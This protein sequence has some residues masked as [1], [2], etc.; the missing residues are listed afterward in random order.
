MK[1]ITLLSFP[2]YICLTIF[3][4]WLIVVPFCNWG[5]EM[6]EYFLQYMFRKHYYFFVTKTNLKQILTIRI[7]QN[8]K[9]LFQLSQYNPSGNLHILNVSRVNWDHLFAKTTRL[10]LQYHAWDVIYQQQQFSSAGL[11]T[12]KY[13]K[14]CS[15]DTF[16]S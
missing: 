8:T 3:Y 10:F 12:L 11:A 1:H 15:S 2:R 4:F 13:Y 5:N 7:T 16:Y 6:V 9:A 14:T